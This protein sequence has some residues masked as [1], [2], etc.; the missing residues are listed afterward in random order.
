VYPVNGTYNFSPSDYAVLHD[1]MPGVWPRPHGRS[2][3]EPVE[4]LPRERRVVLGQ[5][6]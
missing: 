5:E 4:Q 3:V 2:Y 1:D 6:V